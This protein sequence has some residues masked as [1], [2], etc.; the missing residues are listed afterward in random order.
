[1]E[2]HY[3]FLYEPVNALWRAMGLP[4]HVPDHLIMAMLV[5]VLS[6]IVFPLATRNLSKDAPGKLQ[7]FLELFVSGIKGLLEDIVGHGSSQRFLNIIG[8]FA[9]FIF[10]SNIFGL[11]FFLQPPTGNVNTTFALS[12]SAFLYYNYQGLKAQG[13]AHYIKHFMGPVMW[14]APLMFPIE[15]IGHLARILSLGMR[16]FGNITGEHTATGIFVGMFPLLLPWP[17]MGLGIF[18]ASLQT[19]VFIMLTMV[20]IS[21]A[22]AAEE[23]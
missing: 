22:V 5:L 17:M 23:H 6:A 9:V 3:S 20:Y 8:A 7:H 16:L 11:F 15:V 18:G 21:G 14:L 10:I 1:M 19:F 4:G 2:H 12:L 13:L